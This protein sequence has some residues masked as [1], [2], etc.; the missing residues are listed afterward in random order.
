MWRK[1]LEIP[2]QLEAQFVA[3]TVANLHVKSWISSIT[4]DMVSYPGVAKV[5]MLSLSLGQQTKG[6]V[7]EAWNCI[8]APLWLS[9]RL[10]HAPIILWP[11]LC[12]ILELCRPILGAGLCLL[13]KTLISIFLAVP[14]HIN[15]KFYCQVFVF[16]C[17]TQTRR[18]TRATHTPHH[19]NFADCKL[20]AANWK[21]ANPFTQ[22]I[23]ATSASTS[24]CFHKAL[25]GF[26]PFLS[27]NTDNTSFRGLR[28]TLLPGARMSINLL[29]VS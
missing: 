7:N 10:L 23:R 18:C 17:P 8:P 4:A 14:A 22:W 13:F 15:L 20:A 1:N 26:F 16:A 21:S 19:L 27:H 28:N 25:P 12:L 6:V 29:H 5:N 2:T 11:S 3:Q 24:C 9:N